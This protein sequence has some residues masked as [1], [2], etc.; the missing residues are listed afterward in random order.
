MTAIIFW[1]D[2]IILYTG[3]GSP[4]I[5]GPWIRSKIIRCAK[6]P[7]VST[8]N[9]FVN[10][11]LTFKLIYYKYLSICNFKDT[12]IMHF[13]LNPV[14][15]YFPSYFVKYYPHRKIKWRNDIAQALRMLTTLTILPWKRNRLLLARPLLIVRYIKKIKSV[16]SVRPVL[17][18]LASRFWTPS[19]RTVISRRSH[20]FIFI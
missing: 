8:S 7:T 3:Y 15:Y 5:V 18:K 20:L 12:R 17:I 1:K 4:L 19:A 16:T 2:E 10:I 13:T 9:V 14:R 11:L 6:R